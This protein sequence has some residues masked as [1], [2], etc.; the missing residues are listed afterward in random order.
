MMWAAFF[1]GETPLSDLS[2]DLKSRL[3]AIRQEA[4]QLLIS[5][6]I[7]D[8]QTYGWE[9][10]D[11]V[12]PEYVGHAMW[13][14]NPPFEPDWS[15]IFEGTPVKYKPTARDEILVLNG[16]DFAGTMTFARRSLG[17]ALLYS[18]IVESNAIGENVEF[19]HEY[20]TTMQWLNVASDRI[21]DYFVMASFGKKTAQ[22]FRKA[23]KSQYPGRPDPVFS[24]PFE[25]ALV[26]APTDDLELLGRLR[27]IAKS[28]QDHRA[29]RNR[30]VH[31]VATNTAKLTLWILRGQRQRAAE[32][33]PSMNSNTTLQEE[34]PPNEEIAPAIEQLTRW[35][36]E[37]VDMSS[38]VFEF[39]HFKRKS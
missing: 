13:Q 38:L 25:E 16:E 31:D 37:L 9:D 36:L 32:Q 34:P 1:I 2:A 26:G 3:E 24:T 28:V 21:R 29:S 30:I 33:S 20:A 7:H 27:D 11:T 15:S 12:D 6:G 8:I 35:Y 17:V 4:E 10:A 18:A 5:H 23:Y 22:A 19:W 39:E 14:M